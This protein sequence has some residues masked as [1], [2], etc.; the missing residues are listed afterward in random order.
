MRNKP[1]S[2]APN[3]D[4]VEFTVLVCCV[5]AK[6]TYF[7]NL[8]KFLNL[9]LHDPLH[10]DWIVRDAANSSIALCKIY[11]ILQRT[12]HEKMKV[13]LHQLPQL[14]FTQDH[15]CDVSLTC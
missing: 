3:D 7:R 12:Q 2:S 6:Y 9:W 8:F 15:D 11:V 13:L 4:F 14:G 1:I 10:K 5:V